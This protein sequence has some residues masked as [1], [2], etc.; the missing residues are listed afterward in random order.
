MR[1][2]CLWLTGKSGAG[3]TTLAEPLSQAIREMGWRVEHIDGDWMR[4]TGLSGD[5]G[6]SK[7]DRDENIRRIG[8][9]VDLL[10]RNGIVVIVSAISPYRDARDAIRAKMAPRFYE[11]YVTCSDQ[12][13]LK[14]DPKGLYR[15]GIVRTDDYYEPPLS[16]ELIVN[17]D[18]FNPEQ[19]VNHVTSMLGWNTKF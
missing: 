11:I 15:R 4:T 6:F 16:P 9:V 12:T 3:K 2:F 5:L 10:T 1:E 19:A 8:V 18:V 17:T 7:E 13:L 14:R